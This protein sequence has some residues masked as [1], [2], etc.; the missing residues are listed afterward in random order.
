M[1]EVK[2]YCVSLF[3]NDI[4]DYDNEELLD[5]SI[6]ISYFKTKFVST[7]SVQ[8]HKD[9]TKTSGYQNCDNGKYF[10]EGYNLIFEMFKEVDEKVLMLSEDH[11]FTNGST[12]N[13]LNSNEFDLAYAPW[14][15]DNDANG[16][17]LC[18][19]FFKLKHLFP[20]P[21]TSE[22]VERYLQSCLV[23]KVEN[24]HKL[25]TRKHSN[26]FGDGVY[27]NSSQ[28]MMVEMKKAGII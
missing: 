28:Q 26:Y 1:P 27:T 11:F 4:S 15:S 24:K 20:L 6:N 10:A 18:V 21:I 22:P 25:S 23:G 13:E 12:L 8:D 7:N 14:D 19:N 3:K 17:I 2:V 16:S 5:P 9:S